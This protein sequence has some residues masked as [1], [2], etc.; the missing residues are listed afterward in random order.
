[1]PQN[2]YISKLKWDSKR[3]IKN[4]TKDF[5]SCY[6]SKSEAIM[7]HEPMNAYFR[8]PY[9]NQTSWFSGDM[10]LSYS[11]E[12]GFVFIF[13]LIWAP[14]KANRGYFNVWELQ[15]PTSSSPVLCRRGD[16]I[17]R[18]FGAGEMTRPRL[19]CHDKSKAEVP[20]RSSY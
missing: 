2:G 11:A 13:L 8:K 20:E 14:K 17:L 10:F 4:Q 9:Q 19:R 5:S 3:A 16:P 15:L 6:S 7:G 12:I 18:C 1:M